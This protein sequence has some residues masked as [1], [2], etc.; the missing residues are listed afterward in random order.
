MYPIHT[1]KVRQYFGKFIVGIKFESNIVSS[2][3]NL[4]HE[5]TN[6]KEL[7]VGLYL[8]ACHVAEVQNR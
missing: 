1:T 2:A 7:E 4:Y 6:R 3:S 8:K 5:G